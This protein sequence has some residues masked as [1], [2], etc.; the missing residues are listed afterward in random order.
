MSSFEWNKIIA[1][2]L[3]AIIIAQVGSILGSMLIRPP[4]LRKPVFAIAIPKTTET[5]AAPKAAPPPIGLLL[6]KANPKQGEQEAMVCTACHTFDK[7]QPNKIGPNL[8]DVVGGPM[9]ED[10]AGYAFSSAMEKTKK[11]TKLTPQVLNTWLTDPQAFIPGTKMTF[12]GISN[13]QRRADV[14]AYLETLTP[15]GLAAEKKLAAKLAAETPKPAAPAAK[16][17]KPA[18]PSFAALLAK[19][20]PKQ[21]EQDAMVCTACHTFKKG[22]PNM[23][24]P[25]LW[26]I[27][28]S[29]RG[30]DRNGYDFS[31]AM[32][33]K[34]GVKWTPALLNKW[35]TD[36][37]AMIPGTKMTFA[38]FS[39]AKERAD[40]IA[41]LE[42]LK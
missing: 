18:G 1:S 31:S 19:A 38:G 7:G 32:E 15:G 29:P 26:N 9:G 14:I 36:P 35:L 6:A 21:G 40:V 13:P 42:T 5:A 17:A 2:I 12:A 16:P 37:Q 34:K 41:Y 3:T 28:G 24:G 8:W 39:S 4:E 23:V 27:V 33:A 22:Q 20:N 25:N 30:E 11:G 10:R